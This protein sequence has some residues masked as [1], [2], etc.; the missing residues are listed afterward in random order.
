MRP[1]PTGGGSSDAEEF[2]RE[3]SKRLPA[4]S[5]VIAVLNK[6]DLI[7]PGEVQ[8]LLDYY[9][10]LPG[11]ISAIAISASAG[12]GHDALRALLRANAFGHQSPSA[13]ASNERSSANTSPGN[14]CNNLPEIASGDAVIVTNARHYQALLH[15]S[16]S[17]RRVINGLQTT[18]PADL[19][20]QDVRETIHHLSTITGDIT[21]PDILSTIFSRFCIGK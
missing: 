15:A 21:T 11:V 8:K 20:A 2:S 12:T 13:D 17:L 6:I 18:L 1:A 16:D 14:H 3:L 4:D 19:I 5:V 9:L 10:H 7:H